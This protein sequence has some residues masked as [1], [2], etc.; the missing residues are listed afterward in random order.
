MNGKAGFWD[1]WSDSDHCRSAVGNPA[2]TSSIPGQTTQFV[3]PGV[4]S[5]Q[6]SVSDISDD[7]T[8]IAV[9]VAAGHSY[10]QVVGGAVRGPGR[11]AL[12]RYYPGLGRTL[13]FSL[14][15]LYS[16]PAGNANECSADGVVSLRAG[17][18]VIKTASFKGC[19]GV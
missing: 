19:N 17:G 1:E 15:G 5:A 18:R 6:F 2:L 3:S 16:D 10:L 9:R 11:Y 14:M 12:P 13:A 4:W 7:A 8:A